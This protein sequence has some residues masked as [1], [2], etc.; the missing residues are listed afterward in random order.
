MNKSNNSG[1]L[2][3][4]LL[5]DTIRVAPL[6]VGSTFIALTWSRRLL[7]LV[8]KY[9]RAGFDDRWD[10]TKMHPASDKDCTLMYCA[11][12]IQ[13]PKNAEIEWKLPNVQPPLNSFIAWIILLSFSMISQVEWSQHAGCTRRPR[14]HLPP[15]GCRVG[16]THQIAPHLTAVTD[17]DPCDYPILPLTPPCSAEMELVQ[18]VN[19]HS[20]CI[21]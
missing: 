13:V 3:L 9:L 2:I 12:S 16:P 4:I 5:S 10:Y 18:A 1:F 17:S 14:K 8:C 7:I 6:I 19:W 15:L 11:L 21:Q 20:I